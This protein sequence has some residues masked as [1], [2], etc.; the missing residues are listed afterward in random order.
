MKPALTCFAVPDFPEVRQGDDLAALIADNLDGDWCWQDGDIIVIAQ[1][2]VSKSEGR[3]ARP[4]AIEPSVRARRIAAE[5]GKEPGL[6]ELILRE[7]TAVVRHRPGVLI[8]RHRHGAVLANAGIDASNVPDDEQG[9]AQV[10]LLPEDSDR[11]AAGIRRR[12]QEISG[13]RLAV[14][15]NDS[16]G[17][18]WRRGSVGIAIGVAGIEPVVD[19]RGQ[20]DRDGR[21]M[22]ASELARADEVAAAAS[23]VMGQAA[24]GCPVVIVRGMA[25]AVPADG[26]TD[27]GS[28]DLVRNAEMDLFR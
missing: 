28:R 5:V 27:A 13:R 3:F 24:E 16:P 7:S 20:Y 11:S 21:V 6:V 4:E 23:I 22:Q 26:H 12:L 18:A 9:R 1:K 25:A 2:V 10:L 8:T 17:R 14:I 19:L 15:V